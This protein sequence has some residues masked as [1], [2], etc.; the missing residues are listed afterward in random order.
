MS[1]RLYVAVAWDEDAVE[2]IRYHTSTRDYR[3][4]PTIRNHWF[5][6]DVAVPMYAAESKA[7]V[8]NY[9]EANWSH[10]PYTINE[11]VFG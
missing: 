11:V 7:E 3:D 2:H 1:K 8:K 10:M 4:L 5:V 6:L 9:M